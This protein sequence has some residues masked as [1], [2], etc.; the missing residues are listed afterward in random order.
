MP[1]V[2]LYRELFLQKLIFKSWFHVSILLE[3]VIRVNHSR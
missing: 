3:L 1:K 2:V